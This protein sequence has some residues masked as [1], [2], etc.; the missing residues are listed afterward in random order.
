MTY[1]SFPAAILAQEV[2]LQAW[3]AWLG[4]INVIGGL[5]FIRRAEA[6][7]V[8]LAILGN[9]VVMNWL[10]MEFGYQRILGLAHVI[11]WTPL[12]VYLWRRRDHWDMSQLSGKW[13]AVLFATN[14]ISL[15]IDYVDVGR[16][17]LGERI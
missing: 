17:L 2:W 1:E 5:Y 13:L 6:K 9:A 12:L 3:L 4:F 11:F 7:W 15:V 16:Y 10:F 14:A 8:L